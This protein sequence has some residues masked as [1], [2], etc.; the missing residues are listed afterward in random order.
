MARRG[1]FSF[2][3]H[4][5]RVS[6]PLKYDPLQ[7]HC[8]SFTFVSEDPKAFSWMGET[9]VEVEVPDCVCEGELVFNGRTLPY[10]NE[11]ATFPARFS[12][13]EAV[14]WIPAGESRCHFEVAYDEF[15]AVYRVFVRNRNTGAEKVFEGVYTSCRPTAFYRL[16]WDETGGAQAE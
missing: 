7:N 10:R 12:V 8:E 6:G 9:S 2:S 3:N 15:R 14:V 11:T 16:V 4:T 5:G 13:D 1:P